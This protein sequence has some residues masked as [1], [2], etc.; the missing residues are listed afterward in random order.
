MPGRGHVH[1]R[2]R[3]PRSPRSLG[4][5]LR[6]GRRVGF[7]LRRLLERRHPG[8]RREL[9]LGRLDRRLGERRRGRRQHGR[10]R[11]RIR[12][13]RAGHHLVVRAVDGRSS[14]RVHRDAPEGRPRLRRRRQERDRRH[15]RHHRDLRSEEELVVLRSDPQRAAVEPRRRPSLRRAGGDHRRRRQRLDGAAVGQRRARDRRP[16]RPGV[17]AHQRRAD[18]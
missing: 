15:P 1:P 3:R 14:L 10:Q 16:L 4:L 18:A 2:L 11:R 7:L 5:D 9:E 13:H 6:R 8:H 12:R 17:G